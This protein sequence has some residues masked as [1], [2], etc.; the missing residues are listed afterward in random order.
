MWCGVIGKE[1]GK[2]GIE[3]VM[4][5]LGLVRVKVRV[6]RKDDEIFGGVVC[7]FLS[8]YFTT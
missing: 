6:G 7:P 2:I 4:F 3:G 1:K 8:L 5:A